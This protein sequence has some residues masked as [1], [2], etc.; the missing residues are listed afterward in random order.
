MGPVSDAT[1]SALAATADATNPVGYAVLKKAIDAN[2]SAI[3]QLLE[4]LPQKENAGT[5]VD[6]KI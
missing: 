4:A 2:S 1:L 5:L 6:V 3:A